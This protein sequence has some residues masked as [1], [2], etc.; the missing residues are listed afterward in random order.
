MRSNETI[1]GITCGDTPVATLT[2]GN[3]GTLTPGQT[4]VVT[5]TFAQTG[6]QANDTI[7]CS[8]TGATSSTPVNSSSPASCTG[9]TN[10]KIAVVKGNTTT[11][12]VCVSTFNQGAQ[13]FDVTFTATLTN[14]G[15]ETINSITCGDVPV[16]TLTGG[17]PGTLTP[18]QTAVITGTYS[19]GAALAN[20]TITCNGT[21]AVTSTPV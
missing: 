14:T 6:A 13:N 5:G 10:P 4:A 19:Q 18:G 20:D 7:S 16:A 9:T 21:S 12:G 15:N 8:G 1:N 17:N 2:G 3:V 11:A